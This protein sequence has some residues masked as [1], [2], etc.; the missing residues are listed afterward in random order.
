[1]KPDLSFLMYLDAFATL[2]MLILTKPSQ[3]QGQQNAYTWGWLPIKRD[4]R[5]FIYVLKPFQYL[6]MS[7]VMRITSLLFKLLH[8]PL[9]LLLIIIQ[10][11]LNQI[12]I[13]PHHVLP[14]L[15]HP[16]Q[17]EI[18]KDHLGPM[19]MPVLPIVIYCVAMS[20]LITM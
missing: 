17:P 7:S 9:L 6:E 2:P 15:S 10:L 14:S 20:M 1:M 8:H 11:I 4:L 16:D 12:L 5:F 19:L 3:N 18:F 13:L